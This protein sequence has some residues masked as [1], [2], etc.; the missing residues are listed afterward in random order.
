MEIYVHREVNKEAKIY[1]RGNRKQHKKIKI[2]L[3][4]YVTQ[5]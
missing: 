5:F 2:I 3:L 4:Y 1:P